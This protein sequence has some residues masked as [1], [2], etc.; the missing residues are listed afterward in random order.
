MGVDSFYRK[1][2][3]SDDQWECSILLADLFGGF[4]HSTAR[5]IRAWGDGICYSHYGELATFD[6]DHLTRLVRMAHDRCIRA[7]VGPSGPGMVR[8][9]LFKR[10][11][12]SGSMWERHPTWEEVSE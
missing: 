1:P 5:K 12:R 6:F 3:M 11:G 10:K 7:A 2:W 9:M 8:I 4:H